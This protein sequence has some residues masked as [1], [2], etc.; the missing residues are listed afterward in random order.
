MGTDAVDVVRTAYEA[1]FVRSDI[2]E[3]LGLL[4]E[5]M[6]WHE[7]EGMPYGGVYRGGDAIVQNVFEPLLGDVP[8]FAATPEEF[9]ASG[10]QVAVIA[11]YTGTAKA[12]GNR[13]DLPVVHVWEVREGRLG[14]FRQ[15]IDTVLFREVVEAGVGASA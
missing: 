3:F 7:A 8:D 13:L 10:D 11:R 5:D 9:V 15:F 2:P 1:L 12:T 14:R 6:E 4:T